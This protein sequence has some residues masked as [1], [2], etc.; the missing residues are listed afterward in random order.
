[1]SAAV[2]VSELPRNEQGEFT[3]KERKAYE[4]LLEF[5]SVKQYLNADA[6]SESTREERLY[7]LGKFLRAMDLDPDTLVKM[8][9]AKIKERWQEYRKTT[10]ESGAFNAA[11][12]IK[13]FYNGYHDLDSG[14][15]GAFRWRRREARFP[16]PKRERYQHIPTLQEAYAMADAAGGVS[17]RNRAVVL[18]ALQSGVRINALSRLTIGMVKNYLYPEVQVPIPLKI[19]SDI[20][21]KLRL[22]GLG[23][24]Y[25]FLGEEAAQALTLYFDERIKNGE[26]LRGESPLFLS[27]KKGPVQKRRVFGI[28]KKAAEDSGLDP[29]TVWPHLLR[30]AFRKA[31]NATP[32]IDDDTKTALM[33]WRVPGSRGNYFDQTDLDE[34][35]SKYSTIN[36][37]RNGS[38][39]SKQVNALSER[40]VQLEEE[41]RRLRGREAEMKETMEQIR[42]L[43]R[44]M[45]TLEMLSEER[46]QEILRLDEEA[47]GRRQKTSG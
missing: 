37:S 30:K 34:V 19:T 3:S 31:L 45:E 9:I 16:K 26:D 5:Q 7:T 15:D 41:N 36:W 22:Y 20:D 33:G 47:S 12:T 44:R 17:K 1:M 6:V 27:R 40:V 39:F 14:D 21:T 25:T 24:Y 46:R 29:K 4:W 11:L 2:T 32:G 28:I 43:Q 8:E 23:Y 38:V 42:I 13:L 35:M 10:T 18:T